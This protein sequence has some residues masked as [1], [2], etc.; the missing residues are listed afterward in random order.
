MNVVRRSENAV[1]RSALCSVFGFSR[2]LNVF[3]SAFVLCLACSA[4]G[5]VFGLDVVFGVLFGLDVV[6]GV[7]FGLHVVFSVRCSGLNVCCDRIGCSA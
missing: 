7:L 1:R 2:F 4:F 3:G 6:F 5:V